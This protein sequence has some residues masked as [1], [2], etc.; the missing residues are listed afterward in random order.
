MRP[1]GGKT[2]C[3]HYLCYNI[4]LALDTVVTNIPHSY[5]WKL[6]CPGH[7]H[8]HRSINKLLLVLELQID[9]IKLPKPIEKH[10]LIE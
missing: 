4:T 10:Y 2:L 3:L 6:S 7:S 8:N 1:F 5:K 9:F